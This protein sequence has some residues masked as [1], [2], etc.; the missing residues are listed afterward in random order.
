M[1]SWKVVLPASSVEAPRADTDPDR[2][3]RG[4][5]K[6]SD[7]SFEDPEPEGAVGGR[8][9]VGVGSL[10]PNGFGDWDMES[11]GLSMTM[12]CNGII[13]VNSGDILCVADMLGDMAGTMEGEARTVLDG[14]APDLREPSEVDLR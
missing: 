13:G 7:G 5:E 10:L 14:S 2:V 9:G 11:E 1:A 12:A 6:Y 4:C 8:V 3:R